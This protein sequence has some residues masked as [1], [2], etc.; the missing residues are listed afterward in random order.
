MN[1]SNMDALKSLALNILELS[2]LLFVFL[3]GVRVLVV[4][5]LYLSGVAQTKQA[6]R[7]NYPVEGLPVPMCDMYPD[8]E[9][10]KEYRVAS[11]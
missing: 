9:T 7:R 5:Y 4:L 8:A 11:V 6:I 2:T 3:L 1:N 10:R